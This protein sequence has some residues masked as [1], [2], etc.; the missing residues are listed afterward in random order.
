LVLMLPSHG[1]THAKKYR[2]IQLSCISETYSAL[3]AAWICTDT[4]FAREFIAQDALP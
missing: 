2:L 3:G 1:R 4:Y